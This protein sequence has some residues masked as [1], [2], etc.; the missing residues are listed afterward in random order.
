[1]KPMRKIEGGLKPLENEVHYMLML[2]DFRYF[3]QYTWTFLRLPEPTEMQYEIADY[4]QE[5]HSRSVLQALRGIGK[6][7]ETGAFACW[8]LWRNANEKILIISQSG[9]HSDNIAGFVM[10]LIRGMDVL[11]H[12]IPRT[13]QRAATASFDVNGCEVTVQP[14]VKSLGITSQLQGNRATL[15]IA[16]DVEGRQNSATEQMR[17]K[18]VEATA[19]FEAILTTDDSSQIL[20][21]G[22]PQS[23]ESIYNGMRES[24]Y[25]TRIFPARYP[26]NT[27]VY[28]GCLAPYLE[29]RILETK[30][31]PEGANSIVFESTTDVRFTDEDLAIREAR[32]G[33]SGFKLQFMLDTTLS[34]A[35]RYPLKVKDFIVADLGDLE[36]PISMSW[37]S[38]VK[39]SIKDI[40]NIAFT[41]DTL[42]YPGHTAGEWSHYTEVIMSIDPSGRGT[43]ETGY[44]VVASMNSKLYILEVGGLKGGYTDENLVA[45]MGIAKTYK[46][47]TI[48]AEGNFGDGMYIQLLTPIMK[49]IYP[50]TIEETKSVGQK[51]LRIIDTIEPLLNQHRIV[52]SYSAIKKDVTWA[53]SDPS[54]MSYSVIHQISHITKD[55]G[56]L[57]HDDRLD[58]LAIALNYFKDQVVLSEGEAL[59]LYKTRQLDDELDYLISKF[60]NGN[61][62]SS[63]PNYIAN[64]N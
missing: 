1:M 22:T 54:N 32:Y 25:V 38:D 17:G 14:S 28:H 19:E 20:V 47:S 57:R 2:N 7:W 43:D 56:S 51:E 35:E 3:L 11:Q 29:Q 48:F 59:E 61:R 36:A 23:V 50:C 33:R 64:Y 24:G 15:L 42:Q 5:G 49:A 58:A 4:L 21:L 8:R 12:L 34:D 10:R 13:D 30:E 53:L 41:G 31:N 44:S 52:F 18:L 16:D 45:L 39:S 26:E 55:R 63:E 62:G 9:G 37:S 46:V 60:G 6:T 27:D 40:P